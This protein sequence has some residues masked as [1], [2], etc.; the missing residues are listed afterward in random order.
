MIPDV[1]REVCRRDLRTLWQQITAHVAAGDADEILV[2]INLVSQIYEPL[3]DLRNFV[4]VGFDALQ[5]QPMK[6][7]II[8]ISFTI[9]FIEAGG[10]S[11]GREKLRVV[12]QRGKTTR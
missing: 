11:G 9:D 4:E 6:R 2:G 5:I 10:D 8:R 7:E 1:V 12:A 3:A